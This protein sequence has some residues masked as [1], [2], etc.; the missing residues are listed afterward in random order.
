MKTFNFQLLDNNLNLIDSFKTQKSLL[1]YC[2]GLDNAGRG[3]YIYNTITKKT[4][5][6][7]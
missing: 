4:V 5:Q 3:F 6:L 1:K 7:F 2:D